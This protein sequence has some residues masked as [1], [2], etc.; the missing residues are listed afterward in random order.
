MRILIIED[1]VKMAAYLKNGL[2]EEGFVVDTAQ[3]GE[4]GLRMAITFDYDLI[5]LDVILPGLSGLKVCA[6]LKSNALTK[7][8]PVLVFSVLDVRDRALAAG[9]DAFLLKPIERLGLIEA[10]WALLKDSDDVRSA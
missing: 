4:E 9:A 10:V 7:D 1:E 3:R 8:I 2:S 5:I 6:G